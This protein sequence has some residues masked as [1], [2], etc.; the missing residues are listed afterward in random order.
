MPSSSRSKGNKRR[1]YQLHVSFGFH[2]A[3]LLSLVLVTG[4][5]AVVSDEIDWLFLPQLR[6]SE[7]EQ[8]QSWGAMQRAI[9]EYASGHALVRLEAGEGDYLN[10]RAEMLSLQGK[11]YYLYIDPYT[12]T[13][14]GTTGTL[15][16]QRFF[17]DLHRYFFMPGIIGLPIVCSLALVLALMMYTGLATSRPWKKKATRLRW[18]GDP[19]ISISDGH[20][21]I[22]IWSS[23]FLLMMVLTSVWY[24]TEWGG[25][26]SGNRFE[27][28]RPGLSKERV[29]Q[30]ENQII[31]L[32][33]DA[34]VAAA[35]NAYPNLHVT[36]IQFARNANSSV[37]ILGHTDDWLVRSRANRVF[38][39]PVSA[40]VIKVQ[41][42]TKLGTVAYLNEMA[43]PWHFG[44]FAGFSSKVIWF[45]FGIGLS[46]L[47]VSGVWLYWKRVRSMALS[48]H[49]Y[50]SLSLVALAI[51]LCFF[52]VRLHLSKPGFSHSKELPVL[53][54]EGLHAR[55]LL[56]TGSGGEFSGKTLLRI[57]SE[58]G[59][60][61]IKDAEFSLL[62]LE[63]KGSTVRAG[64][65]RSVIWYE[66][67][68]DSK[69][70]AEADGI[71][72]NVHREGRSSLAFEW[73]IER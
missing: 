70:L 52:Y 41:R 47:S 65:A 45:S 31:D 66:Q 13:V 6:S 11:R 67:S 63:N 64:G 17:R 35:K 25:L 49:Q 62:G 60:P 1:L 71:Q 56:E 16:V 46:F 48:K 69:Q 34:L 38:L 7:G 72:I 59:R 73:K 51:V 50:Y 4:T 44:S 61:N 26:I 29:H 21:V 37:I 9:T 2:L 58:R 28:E 15:T 30:L 40:R 19:R 24:L 12:A 8:K 55:L 54:Q 10:F 33:A 14:T 20:K 27:P 22:G 36:E 42:S 18:K 43:D 5:I 39:D 23:W 53:Q 3:A 57:S 32:D 68:F